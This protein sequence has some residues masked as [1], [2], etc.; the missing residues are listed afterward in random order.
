MINSILEKGTHEKVYCRKP[1]ID[2]MET[3]GV[4]PE[5]FT[6]QILLDNIY[7]EYPSRKDVSVLRG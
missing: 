2:S 3:S 5:I 4:S 1:V 6:G 7:F